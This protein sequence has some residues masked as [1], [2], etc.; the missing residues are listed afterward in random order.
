LGIDLSRS[1]RVPARSLM[2][3]TTAIERDMTAFLV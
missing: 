1:R 2:R 3:S